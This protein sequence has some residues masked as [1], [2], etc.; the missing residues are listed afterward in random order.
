MKFINSLI[1]IIKKFDS[2]TNQTI[3]TIIDKRTDICPYCNQ[4]LKKIPGAK[5]K[6][7]SCNNFIFVRTTPNNEKVSVTKDDA[8]KIDDEWAKINGT[9][10]FRQEK[11]RQYK[12]KY[13]QLKARFKKNPDKNDVKWGLLNDELVKNLQNGDINL[14]RSTRF[15]MAELLH[16][17][18]NY[19]KALLFYFEVCYLDINDPIEI[20]FA[21]GIIKRAKR[22]IKLLYLNKEECKKMFIERNKMIQKYPGIKID[23]KKAW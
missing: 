2:P 19:K 9:F 12:D 8:D 13:N 23:P 15:N 14:Y 21:P 1:N 7:P 5:T 16:K 11:K 17:E 10:E 4:R 6:C 20:F 3:N 22:N 18:K